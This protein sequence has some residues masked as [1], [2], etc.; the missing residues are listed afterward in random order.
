M[1]RKS[2]LRAG[3]EWRAEDPKT[4][5][6]GRRD[7]NLYVENEHTH[8]VW[9]VTHGAFGAFRILDDKSHK[10][11]Y[12]SRKY[13]FQKLSQ[14]K[15]WCERDWRSGDWLAARVLVDVALVVDG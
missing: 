2:E 3:M 13:T 7:M 15:R 11:S 6:S 8:T 10:L 1:S 14:A 5:P 12:R 9:Q 4:D